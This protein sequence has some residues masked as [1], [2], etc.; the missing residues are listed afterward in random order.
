M[1]DGYSKLSWVVTSADGFTPE[2]Y[3]VTKGQ[4]VQ[5]IDAPK[6]VRML[7]ETGLTD[8]DKAL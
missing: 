5:L 8:L 2:C 3:V 6:L 4:K 7:L 1:D